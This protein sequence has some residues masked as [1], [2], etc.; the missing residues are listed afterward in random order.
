[1]SVRAW[2]FPV[3]LALAAVCGV[4]KAPDAQAAGDA[5]RGKVLGYTCLGC[6][7]VEGYKNAYPTYSVPR[8]QGQHAEYIVQALKEYKSGERGHAT[9]HAHAASMSNQDMEDVAAYLSGAPIKSVAGNTGVGE[10]P[11]AVNT[12][13]ACHGRDGVGIM[14]T[15][16]TLSGQHAD[17]IERALEEYRSGGRRNG[18]MGPFASQL[19][20]ED[21]KAVAKYF[22]KQRPALQALDRPQ[23]ALSASAK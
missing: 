15:Y 10:P 14:G 5:A 13:Q 12:C 11:A 17:Y 9:M 22:S 6:H 19:K 20:P 21:I 7:G 18:I 1:M 23:F 8:L 4:L 3:V 2:S 16:P